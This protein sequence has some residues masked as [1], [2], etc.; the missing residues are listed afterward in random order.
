M[1]VKGATGSLLGNWIHSI[2]LGNVYLMWQAR[3]LL[4]WNSTCNAKLLRIFCWLQISCCL[5]CYFIQ[6]YRY[7]K[8]FIYVSHAHHSLLLKPL[9]CVESGLSQIM[10]IMFMEFFSVLLTLYV[11]NST[12]IVRFP[13]QMTNCDVFFS[14]S[15]KKPFNEL[16]SFHWFDM[17]TSL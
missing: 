11:G 2:R 16:S 7:M 8:N 12:V 6:H 5:G 14:V 9:C 15:W 13:L 10:M 4:K 1:L 3:L 17:L